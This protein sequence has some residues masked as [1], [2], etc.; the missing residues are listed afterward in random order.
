MDGKQGRVHPE[1]LI[2]F[3][4][5]RGATLLALFWTAC[6]SFSGLDTFGITQLYPTKPGSFSWT[7]AHWNNG[8]ERTI[9]NASDSGDPTDWT[10]DHSSGSDGFRI[11]G[12]G[13]M[14]MSGS[15]PRFHIN[16]LDSSKVAPQFFRDVEFTAYYQRHGSAGQNW[17][18][19]VVGVRSGPLGHASPG[20][21]NCDATTYYARFRNDGKW[22]FEKELKHPESTYWSGSG[23]NR[24]DPLWN[25]SPL[26]LDRWIGMKYI[27]CNVN[28]NSQVRLE[29]YIDSVSN[30]NPQDNGEWELVGTVTDSGTWPSGDVSGCTYAQDA[31]ILQGNGTILMR[32]DGDT[33]IYTKVSIREIISPAATLSG[34]RIK[35]PSYRPAGSCAKFVTSNKTIAVTGKREFLVYSVQGRLFKRCTTRANGEYSIAHVPNGVYIIR[36][37]Q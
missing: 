35:K 12:K 30:G 21:N 16:S 3:V 6:Y 15:G 10:E 31:I 37:T 5:S 22:D 9:R 4:V 26:P 32:T 25:G 27:V 36:F 1:E 34:D 28:N 19:M 8:I 29:L 20:G 17:G 18:G 33:A 23:F 7:S 24:Q 14:T 13:T 2:G 11:D